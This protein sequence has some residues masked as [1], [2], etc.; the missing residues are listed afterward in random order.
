MRKNNGIVAIIPARSGSKGIPKKNV[1]NFCGAPLVTWSIKAALS[2]NAIDRVIV[3]TDCEEVAAISRAAGAEVPYVRPKEL[4]EDHVHAIHVI[5]HAIDWLDSQGL[6]PKGI[7]ML[8]PTSPLRQNTDITGAVDLF[9]R[10]DASAVVSVTDL[11]KYPT[12]LRFMNGLKLSMAFPGEEKNAQRQGLNKLYGVN[13]SIFLAKVHALKA[14]GTFHVEGALGYVMDS[15][16]SVDINE[17]QDFELASQ[18]HELLQV[19][20]S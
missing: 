19:R 7:M 3:S 12:N 5:L 11:G 14:H 1:M 10:E 16:R 15:I 2:S 9:I 17:L 6:Y 18:F 20:P 8:L 13:G 4:A